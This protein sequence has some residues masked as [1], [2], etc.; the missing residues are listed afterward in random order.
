VY[1]WLGEL[2][3]KI[4]SIEPLKP[5]RHTLGVSFEIQR[6]DENNSPV[7]PARMFVDGEEVTSHEFKTQPGIFGLEGVV[8]I[9]RDIGR[10]ASD[11]YKSPDA[12]RGGV[13]EKVTVSVKGEP[14][15]DLEKEAEMARRRD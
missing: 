12:F 4:A 6:R 8:T 3:Q 1:N 13:I 14:H 2:Q 5:G 11:D 7:G 9:G 10:P 15:H